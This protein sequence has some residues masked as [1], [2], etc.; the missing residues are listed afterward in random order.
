MPVSVVVRAQGSA[1][2]AAHGGEGCVCGY[3]TRRFFS[4]ALLSSLPCPPPRM[5]R[6]PRPP[7]GARLPPFLC[8]VP[9]S[10]GNCLRGQRRRRRRA[11]PQRLRAALELLVPRRQHRRAVAHRLRVVPCSNSGNAH[12]RS[13]HATEAMRA[14]ARGKHSTR[15]TY[16][17][18]GTART[19]APS[20]PKSRAPTTPARRDQR[21]ITTVATHTGELSTGGYATHPQAHCG[22]QAPLPHAFHPPDGGDA[23]RHLAVRARHLH[24]P[25]DLPPPV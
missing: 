21:Y 4:S 7:R 19:D 16:R 18:A 8:R 23:G 14:Q 10:G 13:E 6:P 24:R 11:R 1:Q 3:R 2:G 17:S 12:T 25:T 20:A 22:E 15:A 9:C 5:P